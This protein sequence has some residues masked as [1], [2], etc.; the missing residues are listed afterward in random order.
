MLSS[1]HKRLLFCTMFPHKYQFMSGEKHRHVFLCIV[2][3]SS[4]SA[5]GNSARGAQAD[6]FIIILEFTSTFT[7]VFNTFPVFSTSFWTLLDFTHG[8]YLTVCKDICIAVLVWVSAAEIWSSVLA[9]QCFTC[10]SVCEESLI[11]V[12][13]WGVHQICMQNVYLHIISY[14][15][16]ALKPFMRRKMWVWEAGQFGFDHSW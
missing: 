8:F 7:P 1:M 2:Y 5:S 9:K 16:D 4:P 3:N 6:G 12:R 14:G 13:C 15:G 10:L 11:W